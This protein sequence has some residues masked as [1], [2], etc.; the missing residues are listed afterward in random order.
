[1]LLN[2]PRCD[3]FFCVEKKFDTQTSEEN[4][5]FEEKM[6]KAN[7]SKLF[8]TFVGVEKIKRLKMLPTCCKKAEDVANL[9]EKV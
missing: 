7:N 3:I 9:L 8:L 2:F 1:M 5:V 4:K 6:R